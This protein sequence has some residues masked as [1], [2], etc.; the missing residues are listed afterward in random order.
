ME[1]IG[2]LQE[3]WGRNVAHIEQL[4]LEIDKLRQLEEC[5]WHQ[6]SRVK[7]L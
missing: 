6:R 1:I 5:F 3:D 4:S 2:K 7:W